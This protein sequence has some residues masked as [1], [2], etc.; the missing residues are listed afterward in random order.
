MS[1]SVQEG[2]VCVKNPAA[3]K[4]LVLGSSG[5]GQLVDGSPHDPYHSGRIKAIERDMLLPFLKQKSGTFILVLGLVGAD[6]SGEQQQLFQQ[7]L[8]GVENYSAARPQSRLAAKQGLPELLNYVRHQ[9]A[10]GQPFTRQALQANKFPQ[11]QIG[12]PSSFWHH[13]LHDPVYKQL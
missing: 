8:Q 4:R 9:T 7:L 13:V 12:E 5:L 2:W 3:L 10:L 6:K 11:H 1:N